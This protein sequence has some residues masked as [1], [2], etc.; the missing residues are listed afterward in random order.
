MTGP[1]FPGPANAVWLKSLALRR[2]S[3]AGCWQSEA[4]KAGATVLRMI[5]A[6]RYFFAIII[7]SLLIKRRF[8]KKRISQLKKA[9]RSN[10][11]A[12]EKHKVTGMDRPFDGGRRQA[13]LG[14]P[15]Y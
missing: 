14:A 10:I 2:V 15:L 12:P 5:A 8:G 9:P 6:T 13:P 11:Q 1:N 4:A 7:F 3:Q